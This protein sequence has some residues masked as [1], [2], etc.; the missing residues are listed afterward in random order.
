MWFQ[1]RRAKWRKREKALGRESSG[2]IHGDQPGE[3]CQSLRNPFLGKEVKVLPIPDNNGY[4]YRRHVERITDPDLLGT[5]MRRWRKA[6]WMD[7]SLHLSLSVVAYLAYVS[8][9]KI[10]FAWLNLSSKGSIRKYA[11]RESEELR[12]SLI[13]HQVHLVV[14]RNINSIVCKIVRQLCVIEYINATC[15]GPYYGPSAGINTC[16]TCI[17]VCV[18]ISI[19]ALLWSIIIAETCSIDIRNVKLCLIIINY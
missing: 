15:F 10:S 8:H 1:N 6:P 12:R 16:K 2:F 19:Y 9:V 17:N 11:R 14:S 4:F 13:F 5:A 3:F 7:D 18:L